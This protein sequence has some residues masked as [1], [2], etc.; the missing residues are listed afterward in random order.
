MVKHCD[1][2]I[3]TKLKTIGFQVTILSDI[4]FVPDAVFKGGISDKKH[5]S[6]PVAQFQRNKAQNA[7]ERDTLNTRAWDVESLLASPAT[8]E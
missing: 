7:A 6:A 3:T 1:P 5:R 8:K 2:N 4:A